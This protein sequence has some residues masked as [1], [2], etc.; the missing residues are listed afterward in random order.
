MTIITL[1][2]DFFF[3]FPFFSF[4]TQNNVFFSH[5]FLTIFLFNKFPF[6]YIFIINIITCLL[7]LIITRIPKG[8]SLACFTFSLNFTLPCI[9]PC[10]LSLVVSFYFI[11]STFIL[12]FYH[13]LIWKKH[14]EK[15]C[16]KWLKSVWQLMGNMWNEKKNCVHTLS[17]TRSPDWVNY[18]RHRNIANRILTT[19]LKVAY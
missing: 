13:N 18:T 4:S 1:K 5:I 16:E 2:G 6:F 12:L 11:A 9:L 10:V 19:S 7:L 17:H 15:N 8:V 3:I 14:W